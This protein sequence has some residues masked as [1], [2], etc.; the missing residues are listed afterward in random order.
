MNSINSPE[1]EAA[2]AVLWVGVHTLPDD[3]HAKLEHIQ[4]SRG[5]FVRE[6][7]TSET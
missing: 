4:D 3:K 1:N 2:H 6:S 7:E 5:Y